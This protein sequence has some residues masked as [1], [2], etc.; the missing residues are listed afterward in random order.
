MYTV[1]DNQNIK[2]VIRSFKNKTDLLRFIFRNAN[3]F[4]IL[5]DDELYCMDEVDRANVFSEDYPNP[6]AI[7]EG[8]YLTEDYLAEKRKRQRLYYDHHRYI[9][10]N[11]NIITFKYIMKRI[12][13]N[14]NI[15]IEVR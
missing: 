2:E 4:L 5:D 14:P 6:D 11:H 7:F 1:K 15:A 9:D 8:T 3:E 12:L 10:N 13:D